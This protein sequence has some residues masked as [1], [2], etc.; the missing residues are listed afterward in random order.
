M[1]T[2][3]LVSLGALGKGR[4]ASP[5]LLRLLR[6]WACI[7]FATQIS[8][9]LRWVPSGDNAADGPSRGA[10]IGEHP[11]EEREAAPQAVATYRGQG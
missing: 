9:G 4:S 2:D 1:A 6:R 3:S 7:R 10:D 11:T 8:F 5:S